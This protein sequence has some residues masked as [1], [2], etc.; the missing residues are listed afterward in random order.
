[1]ILGSFGTVTLVSEHVTV[2][3]DELY[4][5]VST[6]GGSGSTRLA[7]GGTGSTRVNVD[8]RVSGGHSLVNAGTF[9]W[10]EATDATRRIQIDAG[11]EIVNEGTFV[12]RND[13]SVQ[14][15]GTFVN[16]GTLRKEVATGTSNWTGVCF[17]GTGGQVVLETGS[18][19][20]TTGC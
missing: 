10:S 19:T 13:L 20:F 3:D 11:S 17:D 8:Q 12:V 5:G 7:S 9:V 18:I 2:V 15:G 16:R 1:L 4:L 6:L 14:D